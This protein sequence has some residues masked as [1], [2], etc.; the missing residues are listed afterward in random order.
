MLR[1]FFWAEPT[2]LSQGTR[3]TGLMSLSFSTYDGGT[4]A[5]CQVAA[6]M[7]SNNVAANIRSID[8]I[9][10]HKAEIKHNNVLINVHMLEVA[11][12]NGVER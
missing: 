3:G 5:S 2:G 12:L 10:A 6:Y 11:R 4:T 7:R 1:S 8:L 9:H